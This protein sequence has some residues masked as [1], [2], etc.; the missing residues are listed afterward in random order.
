MLVANGFTNSS[1]LQA[2]IGQLNHT[3]NILPFSRYFIHRLRRLLDSP[4]QRHTK[5]FSPAQKADLQLWLN[6]LPSASQGMSI[7]LLTFCQPK[8]TCWSDVSL[9]GIGGYT[10]SGLAW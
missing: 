7:N 10:D 4:W 2:L 1:D 9:T 8:V 5:A 3:A 6:F